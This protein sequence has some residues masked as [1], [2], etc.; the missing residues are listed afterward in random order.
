MALSRITTWASGNVLTA[1]DLNGEFNNILNNAL[2]LISPLTAGLDLNG[3]S[4]TNLAELEIDD[5]AAN[6]TGLAR[7]RRNGQALVWDGRGAQTSTQATV[8]RL[9]AQSSGTPDADI[10]TNIEFYSESGDEDPALLGQFGLAFSDVGAGTEDSYASIALRI[11]GAA[12][13]VESYRFRSTGS[14]R[15]DFLHAGTTSRTVTIPTAADD[16]L[17]AIAAT[18]TLT[19]K[20]LTSPTL[21]TVAGLTMGT[22]MPIDLAALSGTAVSG[23][24]Y[25]ENLIQGWAFTSGGASPTLTDSFNVASI[26]DTAV[27]QMTVTWETDS[28][29]SNPVTHNTV[30]ISGG[31]IDFTGTVGSAVAGSVIAF[32]IAASTGAATDPGT[33]YMVTLGGN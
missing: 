12:T 4:L 31:G 22:H 5:G 28:L 29:S 32:C 21:N 1:S 15:V 33:G 30:N 24:A 9:I 26:A 8:L 16:T 11:A 23:A 19:N 17:C 18:Q 13:A 2:S 6:P 3:F 14:A 25:Q 7:I 10:G 20:T 27:G